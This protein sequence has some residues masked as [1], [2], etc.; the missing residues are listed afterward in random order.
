MSMLARENRGSSAGKP[1]KVALAEIHNVLKAHYQV[2]HAA[3]LLHGP[4]SRRGPLLAVPRRQSAGGAGGRGE[5]RKADSQHLTPGP[6]PHVS[7]LHPSLNPQVFVSAFTYY[8]ALGGN[9][10]YHMWGWGGAGGAWLPGSRAALLCQG[11]WAPGC[12]PVRRHATQPS[13]PPHSGALPPRRRPRRPL[14]A[15]TCF[16]DD[17]GIADPDSQYIKRSDCDTARGWEAGQG[18]VGPPA[19]LRRRLTRGTGP[20]HAQL[21]RARSFLAPRSSL[22]PTLSATRRGQ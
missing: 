6:N 12:S 9:D 8:A 20:Q 3:G 10:P 2:R 17:C 7:C 18:G 21:T 1:D 15:F 13:P 14:N 16:L 11:A 19:L 22:W 5:A 4:A